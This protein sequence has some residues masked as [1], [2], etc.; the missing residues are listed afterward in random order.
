MP[1]LRRVL[2]FVLPCGLSAGLLAQD[3]CVDCHSAQD[4]E[5]SEKLH[6]D[7]WR[8]STHAASGVSCSGC[9][10]GNAGTFVELRAHRGVLNSGH[11]RSP[12]YAWNL[13]ATCGRCHDL[14]YRALKQSVHFGLWER[15]IN[16]AP[17][18]R[19]CHGD[20]AT[21]SLGEGGLEARCSLCHGPDASHQ[22]AASS[23]QE[24]LV[25][26][27]QLLA[28]MR[29][30]GDERSRVGRSVLRVRDQ[31]DR[32]EAADALFEANRAW[33]EAI[34]AGHAFHWDDWQAAL[35][36]LETVLTLLDEALEL[37]GR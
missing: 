29:R 10:G 17:T 26:G 23:R 27:A 16:A 13:P 34:E 36:R 24:E 22:A 14:E 12:T 11:P 33:E 30:L 32:H 3:P 25:R 28:R 31:A 8:S 6:L 21:Q 35:D 7:R 15:R 37:G 1:Q 2:F 20:L 9:H 5:Q 4:L 19:T 18:C